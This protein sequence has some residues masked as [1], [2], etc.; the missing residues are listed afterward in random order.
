[1]TSI[2]LKVGNTLVQIRDHSDSRTGVKDA[3]LYRETDSEIK[4]HKDVYVCVEDKGSHQ[5]G[6]EDNNGIKDVYGADNRTCVEDASL[7]G[8]FNSDEE[9]KGDERPSSP[10]QKAVMNPPSGEIFVKDIGVSLQFEANNFL[11]THVVT[12]LCSY[13]YGIQPYTLRSRF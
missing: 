13:T 5:S 8:K 1:M 6:A 2:E 12:V 9:N 11:F 3:S 4:K 7:R 10:C